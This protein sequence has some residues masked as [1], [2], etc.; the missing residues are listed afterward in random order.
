MYGENLLQIHGAH[1]K[2]TSKELLESLNERK[3]KP[4]LEE[5]NRYGR[6]IGIAGE[7]PLW[8]LYHMYR[9]GLLMDLIFDVMHIGGLN[10]FKSY[11]SYFFEHIHIINCDEKVAKFCNVIV[12]ARPHELRTGM[13]PYNPVEYHHTFKAKE[14]QKFI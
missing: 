4:S 6:D 11:I 1:E 10:M 13:W 5:K 14:N 3:R 8:K 9:F 12:A 7:S 2:Q